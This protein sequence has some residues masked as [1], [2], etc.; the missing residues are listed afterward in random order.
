LQD[1]LL[2]FGLVEELAPGEVKDAKGLETRDLFE[3]HLLSLLLAAKRESLCNSYDDVVVLA[4]FAQLDSVDIAV[5]NAWVSFED[6]DNCLSDDCFLA[7]IVRPSD[8][9]ELGILRKQ[10]VDYLMYF[11]VS[12]EE[13][14]LMASFDSPEAKVLF[15]EVVRSWIII[16][17]TAQQVSRTVEDN[18]SVSGVIAK[19]KELL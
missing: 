15:T 4:D 1:Q 10:K 13:P 2:G 3:N 12:F 6:K 16:L 14:V 17:L 5:C 11:Q 8:S 7:N 19:Q 18:L 9:Q